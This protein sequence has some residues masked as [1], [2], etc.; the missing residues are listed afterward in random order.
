LNELD[1]IYVS[2]E[3]YT[4]VHMVTSTVRSDHKAV[5]AHFDKDHHIS[6]IVTRKEFRRKSPAQNAHFMQLLIS[7]RSNAKELWR[8]VNNFIGHQRQET[9][10][11]AGIR[12][13]SLNQHLTD[14]STDREYRMPPF[15]QTASQG[16]DQPLTYITYSEQWQI[17]GVL[18]HLR[19]TAA[20]LVLLP[21]W[22]MQ[23]AAPFIP[24]PLDF[25]MNP[26]LPLQFPVSGKQSGLSLFLRLPYQKRMPIT[27]Q[28][29]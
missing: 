20:G 9:S 4:K 22:F 21:V 11:A 12:P 28:F 25:L 16:Q 27:A 29:P 26:W 7:G 14:V 5:I 6:K 18:D 24:K 2:D 17:F 1:S 3:Q 19:P 8:A 10:E 13:R 23:L 15:K